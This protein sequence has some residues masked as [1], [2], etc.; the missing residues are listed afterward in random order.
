MQ[1]DS[2]GSAFFLSSPLAEVARTILWT[3][4]HSNRQTTLDRAIHGIR[5]GDRTAGGAVVTFLSKGDAI[6]KGMDT[7]VSGGKGVV[8][9]KNRPFE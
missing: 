8:R 6:G 4:T 5:S 2:G 9:R 7:V 3:R 1:S